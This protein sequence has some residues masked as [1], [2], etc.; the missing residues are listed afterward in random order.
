MKKCKVCGKPNPTKQSVCSYECLKE[1][2]HLKAELK[3]KK[4]KHDKWIKS[5]G[6]TRVKVDKLWSEKVRSVGRC[7]Y[8][9]KTTNLQAHHI[10]SR[11]NEATRFDVNNGVCLCAGCHTMSSV[12]SAHKTPLEFVQWLIKYKGQAYLDDLK[13]KAHSIEKKNYEYWYEKLKDMV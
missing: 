8:C 4:K 13:V 9:G 5:R 7:E 6:I 3:A 1:H 11:R 12:F 10:Y 2:L